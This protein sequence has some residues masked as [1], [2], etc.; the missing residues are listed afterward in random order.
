[1]N[2]SDFLFKKEKLPRASGSSNA[3]RS[4]APAPRLD[5]ESGKLVQSR[6]LGGTMAN[7]V[8]NRIACGAV[9]L[10]A[11]TSAPSL[12]AQLGLGTWVRKPDASAPAGMTM[13]VEPCCNRGRRIT[14]H[15]PPKDMVMTVESQLDGRDAA[16]MLGVN[17]LVRAWPSSSLTTIT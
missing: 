15:I 2:S 17:L 14:Y 3:G 11:L 1:V 5:G 8:A 10:W 6:P 12:N 4:S 13:I 16:V 7:I 9:L